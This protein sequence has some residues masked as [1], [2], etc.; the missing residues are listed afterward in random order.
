[1]READSIQRRGCK[2]PVQ[3][4]AI[5]VL[6]LTL[7][8]SAGGCAGHAF[9][10]HGINP[11][12]GAPLEGRIDF[13]YSDA[14]QIRL[15]GL[16]K[17][18]EFDIRKYERIC[19]R[20]VAERLLSPDEV[21]V[22]APIS[23]AD[24]LRVHTPGYLESLK[25][26][27]VVAKYLES[28]PA[29]VLPAKMSESALLR[30]FRFATGGTLRAA[31]LALEHG[32]AVNLGGGFHHAGPDAGGGFCIFADMP[33]A[34]RVLQSERLIRRA[35][36]VDLDVH[37]GNGTADSVAADDHVYTFDMHQENIYPHPKRHNDRDIALPAGTGDEEFLAILREALPD[38]FE[39][40]RPDIVF[41]QAGVD[42]LASDPLADFAMTI[43][44]MIERDATVFAEAHQRE[45]PIVMVLGGG[46]SP[47]AWRTQ[48]L[49]LRHLIET[50][51][52]RT[53]R[54]VAKE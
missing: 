51:T 50:Y 53:P 1:M 28:G 40:A 10:K 41:Y 49:S 16:E 9:L 26:P 31:R 6:S 18:H 17:L 36:V 13:V 5:R 52:G 12:D 4:F 21:H 32:M 48:F 43:D 23:D 47:E 24:L 27:A 34:I 14:Y 3:R 2:A 38:A 30:P 19:E 29:A 33:V 37:Q 44:G 8:A 42:G 54:P 45:V 46:Y 20:L 35:L 25:N 7:C 11:R 15:G 22:P 39:A